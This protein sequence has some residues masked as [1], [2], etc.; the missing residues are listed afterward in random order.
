MGISRSEIIDLISQLNEY[1]NEI[2]GGYTLYLHQD[3]SADVGGYLLLTHEDPDDIETD[4]GPFTITANGQELEQWATAAGEPGLTEL[5]HGPYEVHGHAEKTAGTKDPTLYAEIYKRAAGGAETL[6]GTTEASSIILSA[7][8]PFSIHVS[9]PEQTILIDDRI[10]VKLFG[11]Q[12]GSGTDPT[13]SVYVEGDR[14][15]RLRVPVS[16]GD[17]GGGV[18][19][20]EVIPVFLEY[21]DGFLWT[22]TWKCIQVAN[23]DA[24]AWIEATFICPETRAD[25][26]FGIVH[27]STTASRTKSG[28]ITAGKYLPDT[29]GFTINNVFNAVNMDLVNTLVHTSRMYKTSSGTFSA[30]KGDTIVV[31]WQADNNSGSGTLFV[32]ALYLFHA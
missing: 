18:S 4:V 13:I 22:S 8:T 5:Q 21:G 7:D 28:K 1:V 24:N 9:I 26:E 3:A 10:V 31:L 16:I 2:S 30:T 27:G 17:I 6:L 11:N 32:P 20:D 14:L 25:W 15:T 23:S 12:E 29:D 19:I